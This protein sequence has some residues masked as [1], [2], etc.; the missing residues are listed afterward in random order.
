MTPLSENTFKSALKCRL[1]RGESGASIA[2]QYGMNRVA[3]TQWLNGYRR[4]SR[5]VLILARLLEPM[6][7]EQPPGLPVVPNPRPIS[8]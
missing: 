6:P 7:F 2:R 8:E 3:V 4:P 1:A 5:T